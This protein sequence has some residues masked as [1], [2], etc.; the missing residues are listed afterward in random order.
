MAEPADTIAV[1]DAHR[2]DQ[3]ALEAWLDGHV[4][5]FA[6]PLTVTQFAGGQSNPTF[7]LEAASGNYVLRKKPPG[8]L[9][10][11]AHAVERE[12]RVIAALADTDVPVPQALGLCEDE[13]VIGTP[14]YVMAAVPGRVFR[15]PALPGLDPA[16]RTAIYDAM[17]QV[18]AALH[19]VDPDAVGLSDFGKPNGYVARQVARWSK[20]YRA[21]QTNQVAAMD[22][23][24]AW[25]TDHMPTDDQTGLAHG[26]YRLENMIFAPDQPRVVAVLDWE[27]ATLGH[28]LADLAYNCLNYHFNHPFK[29]GLV[30]NDSA[31]SGIPSEAD[32]VAA[33]CHRTGRDAIPDWP[34]YLAFSLF[35]L[36]AIAQGVYKRGLDGNASSAEAVKYGEMARLLAEL[37]WRIASE[38]KL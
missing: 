5:G 33:Y 30:G 29:G 1:R 3:A 28:P 19:Q 9:L 11:S 23:L 18:L 13:T 4:T 35:R 21:S 15:D 31:A 24:E 7:H 14:F 2:F 20:Q 17:N 27:L 26:D 10:P 22:A 16:E 38:A 25:L 8:K 36:A 37:G 12:Y 6:G 32:Y 34:F